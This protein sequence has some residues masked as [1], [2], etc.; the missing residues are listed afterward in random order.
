[1]QPLVQLHSTAV[2]L[3]SEASSRANKALAASTLVLLCYDVHCQFCYDVH[4][5]PAASLNNPAHQITR[6]A[7]IWP[8]Q[9]ILTLILQACAC[10]CP[11]AQCAPQVLLLHGPAAVHGGGCGMPALLP[12]ACSVQPALLLPAAPWLP[13]CPLNPDSSCCREALAA[14]WA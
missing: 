1:M 7:D 5:G 2:L 3:S 12:A 9:P 10:L 11:P 6:A 14:E 4:C 8:A 13:A